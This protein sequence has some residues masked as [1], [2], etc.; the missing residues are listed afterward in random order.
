MKLYNISLALKMK[1]KDAQYENDDATPCT[2]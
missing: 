2:S 1:Y